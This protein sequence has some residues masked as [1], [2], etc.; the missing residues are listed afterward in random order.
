[1]KRSIDFYFDFSSPYG[2]LASLQIDAVADNCG[3]ACYWRPFLLGAVFKLNGQGPLLNQALKGDYSMHDLHRA[4]RD[5]GANF[6]KPSQ[7]PING[8]FAARAFYW[9]QD[10]DTDVAKSFAQHCF[11]AYFHQDRDIS[12]LE[13]LLALAQELGLDSVALANALEDSAVKNRLRQE[14]D[15]AI[16]RGVCGSPFFLIDDEP[17]WGR[18]RIPDLVRWINSGGW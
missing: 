17:F 16:S 7:F 2:Y 11:A 9:L 10:Q 1:M 6:I 8:L 4:A 15:A 18:D 5:I 14:V 12:Q 3:V 13:T